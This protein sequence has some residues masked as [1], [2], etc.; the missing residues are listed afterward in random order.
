MK[1]ILA[2]VTASVYGLF[3]HFLFGFF[4]E[5]MQIMSIS[6]IALV[7]LVI[8]YLTIALSGPDAVKSNVAAFFRPWLTCLA[9]LVITIIL[10]MEGT[11]CWIMIFPFFATAAGIGGIIAYQVRLKRT[12]KERNTDED[13]LDDLDDWRNTGTLKTSLLALLP[14]VLGLIE[15]DRSLSTQAFLIQ[16]SVT[17]DAPSAAV[18]K[19]LARVPD[20]GRDESEAWINQALGMPRHLR[21]EVDSLRVGGM[22]TAIFEGGLV[23]EETI[24]ACVPERLLTVRIHVDPS[25]VPPTVLDE[26]IVIGGKHLDVQEDSYLLTPL[27]DGRCKVELSGRFSISTPFNWYAGIWA[28]YLVSDILESALAVVKKRAEKT[29]H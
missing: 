19:Q 1:P 9:L 21:T 10:S 17:I 6:L 7:P 4:G 16:K 28:H 3:M 13:I 20:I 18:W 24:T 15:S 5:F 2:I 14:L 27:P 26:H 29:V 22:R 8:G 12:K 25:K 11:I 23:F